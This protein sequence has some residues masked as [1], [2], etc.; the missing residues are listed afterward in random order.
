M[1][2][3]AEFLKMAT[4]KDVDLDLDNLDELLSQL[5]AEELDE[6]N[7]DFDPDVSFV[8]GIVL[9]TFIVEKK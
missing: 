4:N 7:G 1:T 9:I 2:D 5:T 3:S 8:I 6:L